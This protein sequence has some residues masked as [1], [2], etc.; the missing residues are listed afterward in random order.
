MKLSISSEPSPLSDFHCLSCSSLFLT[1]ARNSQQILTALLTF[2]ETVLVGDVSYLQSSSHPLA[3]LAPILVDGVQWLP[4]RSLVNARMI[5]LGR[6]SSPYSLFSSSVL[7][8]NQCLCIQQCSIH[9]AWKSRQA[10]L[11]IPLT[12]HL[13]G[14][15]HISCLHI[16]AHLIIWLQTIHWR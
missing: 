6:L 2:S 7:L 4:A 14:L 10:V 9:M 5:I 12:S 13:L 16:Q 1:N 15:P 8:W 3:I 11:E